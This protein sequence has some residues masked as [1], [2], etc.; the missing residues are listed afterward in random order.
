MSVRYVGLGILLG[1]LLTGLGG[2]SARAIGTP[3]ALSICSTALA[4]PAADFG[5]GM[6]LYRGE[7]TDVATVAHWQEATAA[8]FGIRVSS[9]LR[10]R[11]ATERVTVCL[12][13]GTFDAPVADAGQPPN[14]LRLLVFD[15]GQVQF[16][17]VGYLGH[18]T[19]EVPSDLTTTGVSG[20]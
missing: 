12:Y 9:T 4:G 20:K 15:N 19:A 10:Q 8:E 18:M 3:E 5:T 6:V 13:Q 1:L 17:S 7:T 11:T 2:Q 16:D 14:V